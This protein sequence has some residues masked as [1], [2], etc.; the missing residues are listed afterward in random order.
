MTETVRRPVYGGV[1]MALAA[2]GA[3]SNTAAPHHGR[4]LQTLERRA[5]LA[6][7]RRPFR[8]RIYCNGDRY[9][10]VITIIG[11]VIINGRL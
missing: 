1:G 9:F 4:L 6:A 2:D 8:V 11:L 5:P 3:V 10:K 7:P